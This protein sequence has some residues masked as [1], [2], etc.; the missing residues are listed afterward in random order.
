MKTH[1]R[2]YFTAKKKMRKK[3]PFL[4]FLRAITSSLFVGNS[5]K[6][7]VRNHLRHP[8]PDGPVGEDLPGHLQGLL[9][10]GVAGGG[11]GHGVVHE[12]DLKWQRKRATIVGPDREL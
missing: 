4:D 10:G 3:P 2:R 12:A 5:H 11:L 1:Q 6:S 7:R 9:V 8:D